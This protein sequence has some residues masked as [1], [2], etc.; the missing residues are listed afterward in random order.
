MKTLLQSILIT[1]IT[2]VLLEVALQIAV[3]EEEHFFQLGAFKIPKLLDEQEWKDYYIQ[4][5]QRTESYLMC[6]SLL[7]WTN[8]ANAKHSNGMYATNN[9]G[10]RWNA[11]TKLEKDSST[12][13]I[14]FFGDSFVHGDD[15]PLNKTW[16]YLLDS[17]LQKNGHKVE[18]LNFGVGGY[19]MDQAYLRYLKDG[20]Q[21][22]I[23][24]VVFGLQLE[25]IRR[26]LNVFRPNYYPS[27]RIKLS[28]PR[29]TL[30]E[31]DLQ[32]IN[33]PVNSLHAN[34][35]MVIGETAIERYD[36]FNGTQLLK[37][38]LSN[39]IIIL[40]IQDLWHKF[41]LEETEAKSNGIEL[42]NQI[43]AQ[44][45]STVKSDSAIFHVFHMPTSHSI[46]NKSITTQHLRA[47]QHPLLNLQVA[48][49]DIPT[50]ETFK[51]HY[52]EKGSKIIAAKTAIY[53]QS[54]LQN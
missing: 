50:E 2:L 24:H 8:R 49:Q 53:L 42:S 38:P 10:L 17:I 41:R 31:E 3:L 15:L 18:L 29:F 32:L 13:R 21:F 28:K 47:I 36:F 37:S 5:E 27:S 48:L 16:I 33:S 19:G 1:C 23:D 20:K 14:G 54:I 7:G 43:I 51:G 30:N 45:S 39:S 26:N 11:P 52:N 44:F 12:I 4:F 6:D 34:I 35:D 46:K 40:G 9:Q 22:D 25:N